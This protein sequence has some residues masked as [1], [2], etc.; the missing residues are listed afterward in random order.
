MRR[1]FTTLLILLLAGCAG[2]DSAPAPDHDAQHARASE[3]LPWLEISYGDYMNLSDAEKEKYGKV[4]SVSALDKV[5]RRADYEKLTA[6]QKKSMA[7]QMMQVLMGQLG[8]TSSVAPKQNYSAAELETVKS[9]TNE[10]IKDEM[11]KRLPRSAREAYQVSK[12]GDP[13]AERQKEEIRALFESVIFDSP[14]EIETV[15]SRLAGRGA[16]V[17][18]F[19]EDLK[20]SG[21]AAEGIMAIVNA[22]FDADTEIRPKQT[23]LHLAAFQGNMRLTKFLVGKGANPD[24]VNTNEFTPIALAAYGGQREVVD[25]LMAKKASLSLGVPFMVYAVRFNDVDLL[26]KCLAAGVDINATHNGKSP[27]TVAIA[28]RNVDVGLIRFLI[29]SGADVQFEPSPGWSM[30]RLA[31]YYGR[32]DVAAYLKGQKKEVPV[33]ER[34]SE[35][36]ET[37]RVLAG[38]LETYLAR[39]Q[40]ASAAGLEDYVDA[41]LLMNRELGTRVSARG[42][43]PYRMNA[44]EIALLRQS[45]EKTHALYPDSALYMKLYGYLLFMVQSGSIEFSKDYQKKLTAVFLLLVEQNRVKFQKDPRAFYSLFQAF[46]MY[47]LPFHFEDLGVLMQTAVDLAKDHPPRY[48]YMA[49]S[50]ACDVALL[51]EGDKRKALAYG[52]HALDI[53]KEHDVFD[54]RIV[55]LFA[56]IGS[57]Y[58]SENDFYQA[59]QYYRQAE[60]YLMSHPREPYRR[61]VPYGFISALYQIAF[62][63]GVLNDTEKITS[64]KDEMEKEAAAIGMRDVPMISRLILQLELMNNNLTLPERLTLIRKHLERI[65]TTLPA[66]MNNTLLGEKLAHEATLVRLYYFSNRFRDAVALFASGKDEYL[67]LYDRLRAQGVADEEALKNGKESYIDFVYPFAAN[68]YLMLNDLPHAGEYFNTYVQTDLHRKRGDHLFDSVTDEYDVLHALKSGKPAEAVA[69]LEKMTADFNHNLSDFFSSMSRF[70]KET[71]GSRDTFNFGT[72]IEKIYLDSGQEYAAGLYDVFLKSR[73]DLGSRKTNKALDRLPEYKALQQAYKDTVVLLATQQT[74]GEAVR[75]KLHRMEI[76]LTRMANRYKAEP[77]TSARV[78]E[79][80]GEEDVLLDFFA[81]YTAYYAFAVTRDGVRIVRIGA[82]DE[83]NGAIEAF[84]GGQPGSAASLSRLLLGGLET[85]VTKPNIYYAPSGKLNYVPLEVLTGRDGKYLIEKHRIKRVTSLTALG[86]GNAFDEPKKVILIGNPSFDKSSEANATR[87][88]VLDR[89]APFA[90]LQGTELELQKLKNIAQKA[91]MECAVYTKERAN[92]ANLL[93]VK[94]PDILHVAT[95]AFYIQSVANSIEN[96]GLALTS[97]NYSLEHGLSEGL[98]TAGKLYDMDLAGTELVVLSACETG[99]GTIVNGNEVQ[100]L[101]SVFMMAGA[102]N[103]LI[104]LWKVPD[105]ETAYLMTRFYKNMIQE[106]MNPD[107]ALRLAK[108]AMLRKGVGYEKWGGFILMTQ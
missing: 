59:K 11:A 78:R 54:P 4:V 9:E 8:K 37:P 33:A 83:V 43:E 82:F 48:Q 96:T 97:A 60:A 7:A 92:E 72:L 65:E 57:I 63:Y 52:K 98:V 81:S 24:R 15:K 105:Y 49:Y 66:Y 45:L 67:K 85:D 31:E 27:L 103:V 95:H 68:A 28:D 40:V 93:G 101:G 87:T 16:E 44:A 30:V 106:K 3:E 99:L 107:E 88:V 62:F 77:F 80:L 51:I 50:R 41:N 18:Q 70:Q 20:K 6:Q 74:G 79:R 23:M 58:V 64:L 5:M 76:D 26:K 46:Y 86:A 2:T 19:E 13:D 100:S 1:L 104:S 108:I 34:K 32:D 10:A 55:F 73:Q 36:Q 21:K 75:E 22:G 17:E 12:N 89:N 38:V 39:L 29:D 84:R 14:K 47:Y 25:F 102:K 94:H 71:F 90:D 56:R 61:Q 35:T 69:R 42:P 53:W 91:E